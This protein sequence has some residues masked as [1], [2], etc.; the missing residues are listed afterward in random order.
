MASFIFILLLLVLFAIQYW[1]IRKYTPF[2]IG[3]D[4][5]IKA[6]VWLFKTHRRIGYILAVGIVIQLLISSFLVINFVLGS[7]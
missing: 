6:I 4:N 5:D 1:I 7:H 3:V 2:E